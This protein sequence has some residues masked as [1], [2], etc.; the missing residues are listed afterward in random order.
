MLTSQDDDDLE[1][2]DERL[3]V[4]SS[5]RGPQPGLA[6]GTHCTPL[7]LCAEHRAKL[8]EMSGLPVSIQHRGTHMLRELLN[9]DLLDLAE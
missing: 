5:S 4:A 8:T 7:C 6:I 1:D 3:H 9:F 2:E